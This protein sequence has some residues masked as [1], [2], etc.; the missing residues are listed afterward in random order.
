MYLL[1]KYP[2]KPAMRQWSNKRTMK[3]M[4][5]HE[6]LT[7]KDIKEVLKTAVDNSII[8][9]MSHL[10]KGKWHQA[11]V[12]FT[13]L[14]DSA[15]HIQI[16]P[17]ENQI[18]IDINIDQPVGMS[19]EIGSANHIFESVVVGMESSVNVNCRGKV[20]LELP[21]SI[22]RAQRRAD[23][24][25]P[26]PKSI[27]V[28]ALFW[29]LGHMD[30]SMIAPPENYWQGEL[31]NI[32]AGGLQIG[33]DLEQGSNFRVNQLVGLQFTPMSYEKP[34]LLEAKVKHLAENTDKTQLFVGVE[35]IGLEASSQ[36]RQKIRRILEIV[37]TYE[38]ENQ[39]QKDA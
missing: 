32:S 23:A 9:T 2:Y 36:G 27:K 18:P 14:T 4:T 31:T 13:T 3:T 21:D 17:K 10:T 19:F 5:E 29:H 25:V 20:V 12:I 11:D 26:V 28:K 7:A 8:G 30:D 6:I 39:L 34:L 22:E 24:R 37:Q 15:I 1:G 33:I 38:K 16:K 35:F